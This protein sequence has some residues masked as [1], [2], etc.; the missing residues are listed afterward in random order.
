MGENMN[1][2]PNT[3]HPNSCL[4]HVNHKNNM[5]CPPQAPFVWNNN[6]NYNLVSFDSF[7]EKESIVVIKLGFLAFNIRKEVC[8]VLDLYI[9]WENMKKRRF[10]TCSFWC[11][12]LC[13]MTSFIRFEQDKAIVEKYDRKTFHHLHLVWKCHCWRRCWWR[14]WFGDFCD[15]NM[16]KLWTSEIVCQ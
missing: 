6:K 16:H 15:D 5:T 10:I 8:D 2:K 12:I 9:S 7:M 11:E 13:I 4:T 3:P 1:P 14:L